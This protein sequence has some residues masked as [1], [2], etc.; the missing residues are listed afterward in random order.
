MFEN[1]YRTGILP[2][3]SSKYQPYIRLIYK[4]REKGEIT[5]DDFERYL[6]KIH[7]W[8]HVDSLKNKK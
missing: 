4:N 6:F 7:E 5:Q 2:K 1:I 8:N 3:L